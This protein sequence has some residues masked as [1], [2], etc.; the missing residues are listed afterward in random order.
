MLAVILPADMCCLV[1][2]I[3]ITYQVCTIHHSHLAVNVFRVYDFDFCLWD[4]ILLLREPL[5]ARLWPW[6]I[7]KYVTRIKKPI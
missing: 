6:V 5:V 7:G 3:N 1:H 4:C 2:K